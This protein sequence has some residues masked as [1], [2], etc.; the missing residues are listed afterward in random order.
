MSSTSRGMSGAQ[1]NL[2]VQVR[3]HPCRCHMSNN[4]RDTQ[5]LHSAGVWIGDSCVA[6]RSTMACIQGSYVIEVLHM[7]EL[8]T[9]LLRAPIHILET[10]F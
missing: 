4:N 8:C 1:S 3:I 9:L 6:R 7:S 5:T 2:D 10:Y